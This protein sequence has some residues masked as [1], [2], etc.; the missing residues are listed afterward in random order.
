V[1]LIFFESKAHDKAIASFSNALAIN[2]KYAA[3]R[4]YVGR[5]YEEQGAFNK[6]MQEYRQ[7]IEYSLGAKIA[8]G[9][10]TIDF[11]AVFSDLGLL[12]QAEREYRRLVKEHP[13]YAD[14]HYHLG[15]ILKKKGMPDEAMEEFKIA[16]QLNPHYMEARRSYWESAQ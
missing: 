8:K 4:Y 1:G 7:V 15:I 9:S 14:L 2:P 11:G 5:I 6:A 16:I 13:E 12:D 10:V 3:A